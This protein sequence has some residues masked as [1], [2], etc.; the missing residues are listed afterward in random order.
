MEKIMKLILLGILCFSCFILMR[1]FFQGSYIDFR[2]YYE[3]AHNTILYANPYQSSDPHMSYLY[4]PITIFLFFP[5]TIFPLLIAEKIWVIISF[6]VFLLAIF[7][8]FRLLRV[9]WF[10]LEGLCFLIGISWFFPFKFTLGMGQI[11][12]LTVLCLV[13]FFSFYET[14]KHLA[15]FFLTAS[16]AIKI[17]PVLFVFYLIYKRNWDVLYGALITAIVFLTI[18]SF[19]LPGAAHEYYF[20]I[21]PKLSSAWP[22]VY[23]NQALTGFLGRLPFS[24]LSLKI[25]RY[26]IPLILMGITFWAVSTNK[27]K[28]F[29]LLELGSILPILLITSSFSWQHH[30]VILI[31]SYVIMIHFLLKS[32]FPQ[33]NVR[34]LLFVLVISFLLVGYNIKQPAAIPILLQSHVFFG[35]VL[36]WGIYVWVIGN[37]GKKNT[38]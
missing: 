30:F 32:T 11:N 8:L 19:T 13:L 37:Y 23:Y 6:G 22:T 38:T 29:T 2:V 26:G 18:T 15:G 10:S 21:L 25:L 17:S 34:A 31:I 14:K 28:S 9:K 33:K 12:M 4:P 20:D 3:A 35:C 16:I 27:R 36:L 7:S 1:V 5:L 24:L